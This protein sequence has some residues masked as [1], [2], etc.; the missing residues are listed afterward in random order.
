MIKLSQIML[1]IIITVIIGCTPPSA[2]PETPLPPTITRSGIPIRPSLKHIPEA[3]WWQK[4]HDPT[5]NHLITQALA[6]NNALKTAEA[7]IAE[8]RALLTAARW[9]WVPTLSASG[10]GFVGGGW[11]SSF[12][13]KGPLAHSAAFAQTGNLNFRGYYSG[14]TPSYSLNILE[15]IHKNKSAEASLRMQ[16][17]NF[18][19]TRL[20]IISQV[21]G[22]YFM[23]LGQKEQLILQQQLWH[24]FKK[25]RQLEWR[26]LRGGATDLSS[27][28]TWDEQIADNEANTTAIKDSI[29][30]LE[31]ALQ[32]LLNRNPDRILTNT[33]IRQLH[34]QG[35]LPKQ[36]P[37]AVLKN[38]PDIIMA[39]ENLKISTANVGL[40]YAY[41]FP[42]ISL[43]GL[44]GG[45]SVELSHLLT[46]STN[47]WV[48]EAMAS[49]PVLNG[50][51]YAQVQA[52]K[53]GYKAAY[54]TYVHTL[55]TVFAD[56]DNSL[57]HQQA[58]DTAYHNTLTAYSAAQKTYHLM[59]VRYQTG[60]VS[61]RE[62]LNAHISVDNA[63][64][65]LNTAK[66]Q[67]LDSLVTLYQSLAGGT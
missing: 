3:R 27:V 35:M 67:Q 50:S 66:M 1:A 45:A 2:P 24:D 26:R 62:R 43:T 13:P 18:E 17:A 51:Q 60:M 40:A 65:N 15:N 5:L 20:S 8:A 54:Y 39:E 52:A 56:V 44:L 57:T 21:T 31:N 55:R 30:Q 9:S 41:F 14:F 53:A 7:N 10:N 19:N 33:S 32:V 59:D 16:Q 6:N 11:D 34:A 58:M 48:A 37:S 38:R 61:D 23:L 28:T 63:A 64:L 47:V 22:T 36:L 29:A 4:M 25:L 42:T 49:L 46:L 12:T